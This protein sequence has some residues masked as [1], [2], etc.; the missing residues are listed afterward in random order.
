MWPDPERTSDLVTF[1]EEILS[2]KLHFL[3]SDVWLIYFFTLLCMS[4]TKLAEPLGTAKICFLILKISDYL[5]FVH[6]GY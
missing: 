4:K 6:L 5:F 3:C 1:A 2:G